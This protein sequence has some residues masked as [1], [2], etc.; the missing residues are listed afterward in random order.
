MKVFCGLVIQK[1]A[2]IWSVLRRLA[3]PLVRTPRL[4]KYLLF[5]S[6]PSSCK[7][8]KS[9]DEVVQVYQISHISSVEDIDLLSLSQINS[10]P[11][12]NMGDSEHMEPPTVHRWN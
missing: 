11:T 9:Q 10:K 12:Q 8:E 5:V 7:L 4:Y 6:I 3:D 1:V 2:G